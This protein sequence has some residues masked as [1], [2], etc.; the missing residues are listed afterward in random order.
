[1][2][3][4]AGSD[5]RIYRK[6]LRAQQEEETRQ[7]IVDAAIELH[8][9]EGFPGA[10]ISAIAERAGVGR[11]TVYRHFPDYDAI[12]GACTAHYME[13]NPPPRIEQWDGIADGAELLRAVV[14]D[15]YDYFQ[16]NEPMFTHGAADAVTLPFLAQRMQEIGGYWAMVRDWLLARLRPEREP[17]PGETA[18]VGLLL[19]FSGWQAMVRQQ[20]L[21]FEETKALAVRTIG[22]MLTEDI[23]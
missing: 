3:E 14:A 6:K 19:S 10:S 21:S 2:N 22:T 20:Q 7:R 1:M 9:T 11:V 17:D 5:Q 8:A 13:L 4:E 16:A 12:L 18:L 23:A 15:T